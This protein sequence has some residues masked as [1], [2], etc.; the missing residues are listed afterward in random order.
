MPST[1]PQDDPPPPPPP[2]PRDPSA[3]LDP[4][5]SWNAALSGSV[6]AAPG[7]GEKQLKLRGLLGLPSPAGRSANAA[8][9]AWLGGAGVYLEDRSD[10]GTAP[11]PLAV[12]SETVDEATNES[13]GRGLLARRS[14]SDGDE[15][16]AIPLEFT[17]TKDAALRALNGQSGLRDAAGRPPLQ[18]SVNEYL[19]VA[20]LLIYERYAVP[21][22]TGKP[23]FWQPYLDILPET[24]EVAPTFTWPGE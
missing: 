23:S 14:V 15:L 9:I 19:A 16:L 13:T 3:A 2:K 6:T 5:A 7:E 8:L 12:S 22:R 11:H 21:A 10:W 24:G 1:P 20:C 18:G 17:M 4:N